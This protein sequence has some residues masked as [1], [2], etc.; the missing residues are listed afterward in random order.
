MSAFP[1]CALCTAVACITPSFCLSSSSLPSV[2]SGYD[3]EPGQVGVPL[4]FSAHFLAS[5]PPASSTIFNLY[6]GFD[7][8]QHPRTVPCASV[9]SSSLPSYTFLATRSFA[10]PQLG[11]T[12]SLSDFHSIPFPA[13]HDCAIGTAHSEQRKRGRYGHCP[14]VPHTVDAAAFRF[15]RQTERSGVVHSLIRCTRRSRSS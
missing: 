15:H 6:S 14:V 11:Q 12:H 7:P 4:S 8:P 9:V 2:S 5:Y 13:T 1:T 10:I 3:L